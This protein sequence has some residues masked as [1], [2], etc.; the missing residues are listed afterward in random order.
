MRFGQ[1]PRSPLI[2]LAAL[3]WI[4]SILDRLV[5]LALIQAVDEL[6]KQKHVTGCNLQNKCNLASFTVSYRFK[7]KGKS[8]TDGE[9]VKDCFIHA[10]EELFR[11]FKNK[12]EILKKIK[13][14]P[15][16]AKIVQDR[17]A[18]M[19]SNEKI[20]EQQRFFR[21]KKATELLHFTEYTKKRFVPNIS[22]RN[23]W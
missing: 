6:Q 16:S 22:G 1:D 17:I 8:F 2:I 13:Y 4:L 7:K 14:L 19:S 3:A 12:T 18:K 23:S 5:L 20:K 11:D 10:S 21:A 9:Y 15:Q